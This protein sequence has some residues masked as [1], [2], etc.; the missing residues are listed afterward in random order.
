MQNILRITVEPHVA[1]YL[2]YNFGERMSLSDKNMI[3]LSLLPLL[4][5]FDKMDP[6]QLK[7]QRKESLGGNYEFYI[8]DNIL[9]KHGGQ[10]SNE[11]IIAFNEAVDLMVKQEMYRWCNHP[12]ADYKEV[13]YN[14]RR[15]IDFYGFAEDDLTFD[16][17]K[18]WYYRE[19]QR[20]AK[21][22]EKST[23]NG[24]GYVIPAMLTYMPELLKN[25]NQLSIFH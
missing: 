15:F 22:K 2:R 19:R 17:L 13:D 10:L 16:N 3:S 6:F 1:L 18:R 24:E 25:D 4:K 20:I 23:P 8:S 9:K 7:N 14:I 12:N 11:S 5:P 21:R